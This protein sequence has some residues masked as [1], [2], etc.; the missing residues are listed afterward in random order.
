MAGIKAQQEQSLTRFSAA[1]RVSAKDGGYSINA[2][3]VDQHCAA[4]ARRVAAMDGGH[5]KTRT[6]R[7]LKAR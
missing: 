6:R 5:K 2:G 4:M 1:R 7:V 3:S